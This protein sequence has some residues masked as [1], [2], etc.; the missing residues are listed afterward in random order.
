MTRHVELLPEVREAIDAGRPVVALESSIIAQGLPYP[1]NLETAL[2][3]EERIAEMDAVPATIAILEGRI[4]V[5][6]HRRDIEALATGRDIRK[7]SRG[8]LAVAL[9]TGE[10]G[11]TTV[12][13]TMICAHSAGIKVFATGGIGGV[14]RLAE[15]SFDISRDLHELAE[16]PVIVVSAGAK[17]VLDLPKTL[18]VLETLGVP[19]ITIGQDGFPAFWSRHSGLESPLRIDDPAMIAAAQVAREDLGLAGG[20]LVANPIPEAEEI[21]FDLVQGWVNDAVEAAE[22]AGVTGKQLTPYLL[23]AIA[24]AS[25]GA[26][27]VANRLLVEENA[28]MAARIAIGYWQLC[29][30]GK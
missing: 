19:A 5:G 23:T 17:S 6:L 3:A 13:A 30:P 1:Q 22:Q 12:A 4:R 25:G 27:I 10:T 15:Q 26:S 24:A 8:D 2:A 14:H 29:R 20:M 18:E 16:T 21:P 28:R 7:L 11:A 9:A